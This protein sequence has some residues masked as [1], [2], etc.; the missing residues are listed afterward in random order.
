MEL[1]AAE[2]DEVCALWISTVSSTPSVS[3]F[4]FRRVCLSSLE[5][6]SSIAVG[7]VLRA[8]ILNSLSSTVSFRRNF[9][10]GTFANLCKI[11]RVK[12]PD[13]SVIM[14]LS[15][16]VCRTSMFAPVTDSVEMIKFVTFATCHVTTNGSPFSKRYPTCLKPMHSTLLPVALLKFG[17]MSGHGSSGRSS[18]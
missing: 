18:A 3:F 4:F 9:S 15:F 13:R 17:R 12:V 10:Q 7:L 16:L 6:I 11:T 14:L 2:L 1:R 8:A 5:S